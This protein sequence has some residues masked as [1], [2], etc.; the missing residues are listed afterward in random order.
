MLGLAGCGKTYNHDE[1]SKLVMHKSEAEVRSALGEP[2]WINDGKPVT[3][4]YYRKT[5]DAANQNKD[6]YKASLKFAPDAATGQDKVVDVQF[7]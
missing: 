5:Y 7:E 3:W 1:F 2:S 4:M 6:D